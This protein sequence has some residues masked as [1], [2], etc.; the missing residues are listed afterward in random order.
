MESSIL[1]S[2]SIL[3][4]AA[5]PL[6]KLLDINHLY[7]DIDKADIFDDVMEVPASSYTVSLVS[8]SGE[9]PFTLSH[10]IGLRAFIDLI[11]AF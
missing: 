7:R 5:L 8:F 2:I 6:N 1:T 10:T 9:G 4:T 11:A 3:V